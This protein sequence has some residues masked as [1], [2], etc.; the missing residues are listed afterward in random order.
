M[1]NGRLESVWPV[2]GSVLVRDDLVWCAAGRSSY[3]DGGIHLLALDLVTGKPIVTKRL[4]GRDPTCWTAPDASRNRAARNRMPGALPDILSIS[5][6][7]IVMGW[8]CFD[9]AGNVIVARQPHLFSAT[10]YLD[11]SWWHRTYWQFGNWMRG[12]FGGWPQA[13]RQ[14]TAGRLLVVTDEAIFGFGREKYDVG[15]PQGVHAGHVGVI[16]DGYQDSGRVDHAQ[17]PYRL[18]RAVKPVTASG[19]QARRGPVEYTWQVPV[20]ILVRA[21]LLA[22]ETLLIA[23]PDAEQHNQ[24]LAKIGTLQPGRLLAVSAADG[25]VLADYE[26]AAGPRFD[27]MAA[28]AGRVFISCQDGSVVCLAAAGDDAER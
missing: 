9:S 17:N 6:E 23:G 16:K 19:A 25:E 13:A 21:M 14:T 18:F 28:V 1:A 8:T 5:G 22:D 24:G 12:G 3:L 4:D 26:L 15:N 27:G 7:H 2:H 11:D 10:G 20:S